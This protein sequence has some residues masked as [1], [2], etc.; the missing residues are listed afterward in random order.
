MDPA[1]TLA[2]AHALDAPHADYATW[3]DAL[4]PG[5]CTACTRDAWSGING[6][7]HAGGPMICPDRDKRQP[8]FS[9]DVP[10][11]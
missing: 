6:W 2:H 3:L 11:D 1:L 8:T 5:L 9:P 7:W 4:E 10:N